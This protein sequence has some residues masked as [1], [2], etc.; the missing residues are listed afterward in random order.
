MKR[1]KMKLKEKWHSKGN[2]NRDKNLRTNKLKNKNRSIKVILLPKKHY[3]VRK[4]DKEVYIQ[5]QCHQES[6]QDDQH[7]Q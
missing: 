1:Y 6:L 7:Y 3:L 5:N 4:I 2:L